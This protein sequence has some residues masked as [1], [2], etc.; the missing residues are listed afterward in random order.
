MSRRMRTESIFADQFNHQ[1]R[2]AIIDK[3]DRDR[4][5]TATDL[6]KIGDIIWDQRYCPQIR[7]CR[8]AERYV[9][10]IISFLGG[11]LTIR[12]I[13]KWVIELL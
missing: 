7:R 10:P 12:G 5:L 13:Y 4:V 11:L 1:E 2:K 3:V 6:K 8:T 9:F